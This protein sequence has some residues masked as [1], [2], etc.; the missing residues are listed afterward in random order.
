MLWA[1]VYVADA[2]SSQIRQIS[3]SGVVITMNNGYFPGPTG[4][5]VDSLGNVY[6][7]DPAASRIYKITQ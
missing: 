1:N 7:A 5:A 3:P 4:V 6:V 2:G